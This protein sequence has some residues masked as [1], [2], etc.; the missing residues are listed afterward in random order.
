MSNDK[1]DATYHPR[2]RIGQTVTLISGHVA[3]QPAILGLAITGLLERLATN[4]PLVTLV[5]SV[6]P[7]QMWVG[8]DEDEHKVDVLV[9]TGDVEES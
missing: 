7:D 8:E 3:E 1:A 2:N 6:R 5:L 9:I 4:G